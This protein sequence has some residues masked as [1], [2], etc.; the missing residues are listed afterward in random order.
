MNKKVQENGIRVPK[1]T[2]EATGNDALFYEVGYVS[3]LLFEV[4]NLGTCII[5]YYTIIFRMDFFHY[6]IL[7]KLL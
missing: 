4:I 7:M 6:C 1:W 3:G 2:L 5:S